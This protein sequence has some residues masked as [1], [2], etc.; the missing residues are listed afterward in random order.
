MGMSYEELSIYGR[1]RKVSRMGP[2]SMFNV[3]KDKWAGVGVLKVA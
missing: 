1:L 3:L 2:V